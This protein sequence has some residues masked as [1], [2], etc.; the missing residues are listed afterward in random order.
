MKVVV[1]GAGI[2]GLATAARLAARGDEVVVVE[3]EDDVARHQTGRNSG[4]IHSGLYYRPGS[5]KARLG[6]AGAESMSLFAREH[7]VAVET[8]GK[9]VVAV[10]EGERARLDVLAERAVANGVP[11]RRVSTAE[12]REHEPE[13]SCVA[14]LRVESTGIV[15]YRGVCGVLAD[16]VRAAGG[17]LR[18]G[19]RVMG[20]TH[21][22]TGLRVQ[23]TG[24]D[25]DEMVRADAMVACA[26]LYADRL[27]RT[28]GVR[29]DARIV[30]FR[31][32]Y[33]ELTPD[34]A[35]RV[36]G[37]IYPVPDPRFPF[38]GV[39]LTRMVH[40]GVHAGPNAVLALAREG[41]TWRDV[42]LRDLRDELSWPG[43][44]RLGARNLVPGAREV[45]RSASRRL[46]AAS[47]ARLVPGIGPEDLVPAPAGVRAQ[48]L[49]RDG[50]LVDD[51][52]IAR[53]PRQV[54]VINAP[55][56][57]ATASLEIARHLVDELDRGLVR[58]A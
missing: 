16:Q 14:A 5:L 58:G 46:F 24:R 45:A 19:T 51:F 28:C 26:G 38:L 44:W 30:P 23:V 47:L 48:A 37:L 57:A 8:C 49:A 21:D 20:V 6:R 42:S 55:S 4:V 52:L 31:G 34:A 9:L 17:R 13:V 43:L 29:V 2:V 7:G 41:Y 22:T 15:D 39:H 35:E 53:G 56:P 1:V 18:T 36:H 10:D 32:E 3:K 27:A 54:H 25:G 40:G 50:S 11:A 33:F 12:A